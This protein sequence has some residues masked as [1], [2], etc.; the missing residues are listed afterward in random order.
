MI[1]K[2]YPD[3]YVT[4]L[5]D[6]PLDALRRQHIRAFILDLDNTITEW[7]SNVIHSG[8]GDWF[9]TIKEAGFKACILSNNKE[10]RCLAVA[11]HL[12][13]PFIYKAQKPR[14]ASF[15]RALEMMGVKAEE[16]AVIGDQIFTDVL[17][18]NR[19]GLFTILVTP[20]A[21][22]EFLGTKISRAME[23][24]VLYRLKR[25]QKREKKRS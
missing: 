25:K 19:A 1:N 23:K 3:L 18:G 22:R 10:Q 24:I 9:Q 16:T 15:Y 2:L 20:M 21:S 11:N 5:I 4:S 12:E 17:G 13:I 8:V 7:N 14:R 6:I